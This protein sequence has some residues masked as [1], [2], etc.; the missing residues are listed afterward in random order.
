MT[1]EEKKKII[2]VSFDHMRETLKSIW[3]PINVGDTTIGETY[4][5]DADV[6]RIATALI[7]EGFL[8]ERKGEWVDVPSYG[9]S[10]WQREGEQVYPKY[11][12]VCND[13]YSK[14]YDYCPH[15][16]AKMTKE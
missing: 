4:L 7:N 10:G 1:A 8:L 16:G 13:V 9:V 15:C 12:S 14:A 2:E 6:F 5:R 3:L 11:C